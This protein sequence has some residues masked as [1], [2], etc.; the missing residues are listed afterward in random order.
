MGIEKSA[1]FTYEPKQVILPNG[2][3]QDE[4]SENKITKYLPIP[5][6]AP[7]VNKTNA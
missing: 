7:G 2:E 5:P 1:K 4:G 6:L 3:K